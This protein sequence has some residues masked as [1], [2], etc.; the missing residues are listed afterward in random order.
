[1]IES[2][3]LPI[4]SCANYAIHK[5]SF[6]LVSK[7]KI[8]HQTHVQ[9][10]QKLNKKKKNQPNIT[11]S[12]FEMFG[13]LLFLELQNTQALLKTSKLRHSFFFFFNMIYLNVPVS[14]FVS[15]RT[16][17]TPNIRFYIPQT[18]DGACK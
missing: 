4:K 5:L 10:V 1:M 2:H 11:K 12:L 14:Y 7:Q 18:Q 8:T 9:N 17:A 15:S 13:L 16:S 6:K 3:L